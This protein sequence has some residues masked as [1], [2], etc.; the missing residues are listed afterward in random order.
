MVLIMSFVGTAALLATIYSKDFSSRLDLRGRAYI[1]SQMDTEN[2]SALLLAWAR[3]YYS[4]SAE[5]ISA[6]GVDIEIP[7]SRSLS[8]SY[9]D[10]IFTSKVNE[11]ASLKTIRVVADGG[12]LKA[13]NSFNGINVLSRAQI[14][15]G[16]IGPIPPPSGGQCPEVEAR[17]TADMGLVSGAPTTPTNRPTPTSGRPISI[18]IPNVIPLDL[19][20][21]INGIINFDGLDIGLPVDLPNNPQQCQG[22]RPEDGTLARLIVNFSFPETV[23]CDWGKNG[24]V[25]KRNQY[26]TARKEEFGRVDLPGIPCHIRVIS[27]T[28]DQLYD[29]HVMVTINGR[30]I[31]TTE[32]KLTARFDVENGFPIYNWE[33]IKGMAL[34]TGL[35][36]PENSKC[37]VGQNSCDTPSTQQVGPFG[38]DISQEYMRKIFNG[39]NPANYITMG[40]ITT[41]DDDDGYDC[42]HRALNARAEVFYV[43]P[44]E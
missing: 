6:D 26:T 39:E 42:S 27:P 24:N 34:S 43:I 23:G 35:D 9:F 21:R 28:A 10:K 31:M 20:S 40:I 22:H 17:P 16:T 19:L 7:D 8:S 1:K 37:F 2:N 29:D 30:V 18:R 38:F 44:Q 4:A 5:P 3:H 15:V 41:G 11:G 36:I 12:L 14:R 25:A 32:K 33:S 13:K